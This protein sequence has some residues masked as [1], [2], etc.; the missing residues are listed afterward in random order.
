MV[1]RN[2]KF[3]PSL[4]AMPHLSNN[5][6]YTNITIFFHN[7]NNIVRASSHQHILNE[8]ISL[9]VKYMMGLG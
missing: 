6:A 8:E 4:P 1:V 9:N 2:S 3:C 5:S 7:C